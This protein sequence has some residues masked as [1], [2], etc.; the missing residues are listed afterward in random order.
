MGHDE[1]VRRFGA[2]LPHGVQI[3][4]H[5][6]GV[7]ELGVVEGPPG[8]HG[9]PQ[10]EDVVR[11]A[12][13][14]VVHGVA[15]G[16]DDVKGRPAEGDAVLG[17]QDDPV[18]QAGGAV[19]GRGGHHVLRRHE[20]VG[21]VQAQVGHL[22]PG[23]PQGHGEL[24]AVLLLEVGYVP[25]MVDVGVAADHPH[26]GEAFPLKGLLQLLPL[27]V[28]PGVQQDAVVFIHLVEGDELPALKDPGVA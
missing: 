24:R 15:G 12:G 5:A 10:I 4:L 20:V 26:G 8:H 1:F 19:E 23:L 27:V 7:G 3:V 17:G 21:D 16:V 9:V 18:G 25:H 28:E 2:H 13:A 11:G 22:V 14:D 6:E